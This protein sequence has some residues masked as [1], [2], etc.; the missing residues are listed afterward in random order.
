V[1]E[2]EKRSGFLA[3]A[4]VKEFAKTH[5]ILGK[6]ELPLEKVVKLLDEKLQFKLSHARPHL[7][8]KFPFANEWI[9]SII[10]HRGRATGKAEEKA[11]LAALLL[12]YAMAT[13]L[14]LTLRDNKGKQQVIGVDV[15]NNPGEEQRK[16]NA[17]R[18]QR[19]SRVTTN[20]DIMVKPSLALMSRLSKV[21]LF[22][23]LT[24]MSEFFLGDLPGFNQNANLAASRKALGVDKH[25]VLVINSKNPPPPEILLKELYAFA[26]ES[27]K[28]TSL[29]LFYPT[30]EI[31]RTK[32]QKKSPIQNTPQELWHKYNQEVTTAKSPLQRQIAIAKIALQDGHDA[33][34][35]DILACD[36][37]VKQ[38]QREQGTQK[39][40]YHI[41]LV[42]NAVTIKMEGLQRTQTLWSSPHWR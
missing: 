4:W 9:D 37:F 5:G 7:A 17:I 20:P 23:G 22:Q 13:D 32:Q 41:S 35:P 15:T 26:N 19:D 25:L 27:A 10:H 1:S 31:S 21:V 24:I 42:I 39:A 12:D 6:L 3:E 40:R 18:G 8:A 29:N 11:G 38:I 2:I 30:G 36:P 16:L 34:L 28:T 33:K 14:I